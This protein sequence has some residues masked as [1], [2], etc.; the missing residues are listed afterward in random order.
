M[1]LQIANPGLI[2]KLLQSFEFEMQVEYSYKSDLIGFVMIDNFCQLHALCK[3]N[4]F[5]ESRSLA[6][7]L[8]ECTTIIMKGQR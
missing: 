3:N 8:N 7:D 5:Y 6:K 2:F 1:E 4:L